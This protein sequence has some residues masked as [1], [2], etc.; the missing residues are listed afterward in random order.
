MRNMKTTFQKDIVRIGVDVNKLVNHVGQRIQPRISEAMKTLS[1]LG[2][3]G[4]AFVLV[5]LIFM[6]KEGTLPLDKTRGKLSAQGDKPVQNSTLI[7]TFPTPIV[8]QVF[9]PGSGIEQTTSEETKS[10]LSAEELASLPK[11][12]LQGP[13]QCIAT[14]PSGSAKIYIKSKNIRTSFS[15]NGAIDNTLVTNDCMY[16]WGSGKG[17][18]QCGV[19]Q[20]LDTFEML[21]SSGVI[22]V[23]ELMQNQ[24]S[25]AT[26]SAE[27]VSVLKSCQKAPF[28]D[29]VF[30]VPSGIQWEETVTESSSTDSSGILDLLG[31]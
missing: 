12:D 14:T 31:Q 2:I 6:W 22:S 9:P 19:G 25:S 5:V 3:L 7:T 28:S 23:S 24:V 21:S 29:S 4:I 16:N 17:T 20:Y 13:W 26:E 8:E 1:H 30:T 11:L 10:F 18:K 27:M 15:T